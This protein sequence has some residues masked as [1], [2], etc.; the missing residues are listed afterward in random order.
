MI[1]LGVLRIDLFPPLAPLLSAS[2]VV[3]AVRVVPWRWAATAVVLA[4]LV[5]EVA[6]AVF[7]PPATGLL[8]QVGHPQFGGPDPASPWL[9]SGGPRCRCWPRSTSSAGE[10]AAPGGRRSSCSPSAASSPACR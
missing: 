10:P 8:V 2:I 3:L 7:V 5:F 6:M 4:S 1:D 9:R